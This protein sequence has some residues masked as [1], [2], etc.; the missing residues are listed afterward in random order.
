MKSIKPGRGN[1][2]MGGIMGIF[3]VLFG[4]VWTVIASQAA[5]FMGLFG[6]LWT[7]MAAVITVRNFKNAISKNRE[8]MYDIV[9]GREE[10]DPFDERFGGN[11]ADTDG[12]DCRYCPYCGT[13]VESDHEYCN[14]CGRK[15][16]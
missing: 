8:S 11:K 9:D 13:A 12:T 7:C 6:I 2:M 3:M 16:P 14:Q 10:P 1:S 15:L 4:I 5:W